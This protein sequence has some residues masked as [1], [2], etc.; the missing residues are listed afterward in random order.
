MGN[1]SCGGG[2]S[3]LVGKVNSF[4]ESVSRYLVPLDPVPMH[5]IINSENVSKLLSKINVNKVIGP[6]NIPSRILRDHALTLAELIYTISDESIRKGYLPTIWSLCS[7]SH[8]KG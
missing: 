2:A 6:D 5:Y 7:Y 1:S 3:T 8:L 4:F